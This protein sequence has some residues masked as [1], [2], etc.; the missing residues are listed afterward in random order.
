MEAKSN[1]FLYLSKCFHILHLCVTI[2]LI[3]AVVY[4]QLRNEARFGKL[5]LQRV[6]L[7][8]RKHNTDTDFE[9][10]RLVKRNAFMA[11]QGDINVTS[12]LRTKHDK[13]LHNDTTRNKEVFG[14][15]PP[16]KP[17]ERGKR[18][19]KGKRGP[20]VAPIFSS[21][22]KILIFKEKSPAIL[23]C[24]ATANPSSRI[25]WYRDGVKL[26]GSHDNRASRYAVKENST[27]PSGPECSSYTTITDETR[28]I[29]YGFGTKCDTKIV[30]QWYRFSDAAGVRMPT[31]CV[32]EHHCGTVAPGW[33]TEPHPTIQQGIVSR[34]I[35]FTQY[36]CCISST[37]IRV[38]NCGSF[39]IY[40]F[41]AV[42]F[43]YL[44]YCGTN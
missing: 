27:I 17:G 3:V 24:N 9:A 37:T 34:K 13:D 2:A 1:D 36:D 14:D 35:C 21:S 28:N 44:R 19:K 43:C 22:P 42:S 7:P 12:K 32:P 23:F 15:S 18:G 29:N 40:E 38:R 5:E 30:K 33:L 10:R 31:T 8:Q 26:T 11:K 20:R 39:Y 41:K 25:T 4:I 16:G 6:D